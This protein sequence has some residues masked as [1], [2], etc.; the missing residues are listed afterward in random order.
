MAGQERFQQIT[1]H[2][3]ERKIQGIFLVYSVTD[4]TSFDHIHPYWVAEG[5]RFGAPN[6]KIFLVGNK[7]DLQDQREVLYDEGKQLANELGF[8]GFFETSAKQNENVE[9]LFLE[10]ANQ[11]SFVNVKRARN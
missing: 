9:E 10:M 4:R 1:Q 3:F 8:Q 5:K 2:H 7:I 11:T 6:V